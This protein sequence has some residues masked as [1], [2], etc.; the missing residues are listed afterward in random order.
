M[1]ITQAELAR[2][3]GVTVQTIFNLERQK[4][5][6]SRPG[7]RGGK[8]EYEVHSSLVRILADEKTRK[9]DLVREA[10]TNWCD[11]HDVQPYWMEDPP[12]RPAGGERGGGVE[13]E[14]ADP[15]GDDKAD[16][17]TWS[18]AEAKRR[19]EIAQ[20]QLEQLKLAKESG[21]YI[22][23]DVARAAIEDIGVRTQKAFLAIPDR[24]AAVL[25]AERDTF[26]VQRLLEGEIRGVLTSL[27]SDLGRAAPA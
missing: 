25:A 23:A 1:W 3:A 11:A 17:S 15:G 14:G 8:K 21:K 13:G 6:V 5:V 26:K 2:A 7:R 22:E 12:R 27:A 10:Y 18:Q 9:K 24:I 16:P 19:K 20:A 4:L